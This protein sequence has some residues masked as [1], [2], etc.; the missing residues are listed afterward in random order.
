MV[1]ISMFLD[2]VAHVYSRQQRET[3][4][5]CALLASPRAEHR[6]RGD[7]GVPSGKKN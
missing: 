3:Q 7:A 6:H 1:G 5:M 4:A 2:E